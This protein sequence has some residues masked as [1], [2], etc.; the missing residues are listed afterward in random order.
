MTPL[1]R[2][3]LEEQSRRDH[4][5][6][7]GVVVVAVAALGAALGIAVVVLDVIYG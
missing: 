7:L 4:L 3:A 5:A 2:L 6:L 1:R